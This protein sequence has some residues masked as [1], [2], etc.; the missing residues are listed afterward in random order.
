MPFTAD[1]AELPTFPLTPGVPIAQ[2]LWLVVAFS[3]VT[4]SSGGLPLVD[5]RQLVS[6]QGEKSEVS[7]S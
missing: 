5:W 2:L 4:L 6:E 3:S 1:A 7:N